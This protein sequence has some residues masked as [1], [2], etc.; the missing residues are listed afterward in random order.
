MHRTGMIQRAWQGFALAMVLTAGLVLPTVVQAEL[1]APSQTDKRITFMVMGL[2]KQEHLT[3]HKLDV[4]IADRTIQLFLK[5]LDPM[6]LYFNQ[7]DVDELKGRSRELLAQ[8]NAGDISLGY[9]IFKKFLQRIDQ[10][11]GF[12]QE[13]LKVPHDFTVDEE[14][15]VDPDKARY[16]TSDAE[17][18]ELWRRRIKYDLL[19]LKADNVSGQEAIDRL[20]RRYQSFSKRMHQ[21]DSDELLEM[22]LSSVTGAYDPHSSYMSPSTLENFEIQM[23]LQLDGIGAQ[24]QF[25]DGYTVINKIIPGGAADKDGRLFLA[26]SRRRPVATR[27]GNRC[28]LDSGDRIL[29]DFSAVFLGEFHSFFQQLSSRRQLISHI[30]QQDKR[31]RAVLPRNK[32]NCKFP[33]HN[34]QGVGN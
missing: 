23:R 6:K 9:D 26:K 15:V 22:F 17:A 32:P 5:S 8:L 14:M 24:L 25:E 28:E 2:M 4:E 19:V 7:A 34:C 27:I 29:A 3:R 31:G 10:R 13:F 11:M 20:S 30:D 18:R 16:A 12:A 1:T 21:T 33:L